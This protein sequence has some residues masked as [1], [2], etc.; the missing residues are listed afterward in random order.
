M[1]FDELFKSLTDLGVNAGGKLLAALLLW[2]VGRRLIAF[3]KRI[4][5][6]AMQSRKV[7]STIFPVPETHYNLSKAA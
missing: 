3:A 7:D 2:V 6:R 4:L 5:K 1:D